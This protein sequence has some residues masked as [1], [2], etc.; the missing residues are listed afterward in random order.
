MLLLLIPPPT[1]E[2]GPLDTRGVS[3]ELLEALE[4]G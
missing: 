4:G 2:G 3:L 1:G